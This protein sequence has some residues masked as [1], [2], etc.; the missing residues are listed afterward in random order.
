MTTWICSYCGKKPKAR[1]TI[2]KLV[3][4]GWQKLDI[5]IQEP[6]KTYRETL[7]SCPSCVGKFREDRKECLDILDK[8]GE[9]RVYMLRKMLREKSKAGSQSQ[10][11]MTG[12]SDDIQEPE[13][14]A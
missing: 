14:K 1:M 11:T 10:V 8:Q 2:D 12:G 6:Q 4:D 7:V 9:G 13:R 5:D 3:R